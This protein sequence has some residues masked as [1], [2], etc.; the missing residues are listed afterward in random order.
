MLH[1]QAMQGS[2]LSCTLHAAVAAAARLSSSHVTYISLRCAA[3]AAIS[4]GNPRREA[5]A[6]SHSAVLLWLRRQASAAECG[7]PRVCPKANGTAGPPHWAKLYKYEQTWHT[8]R[9]HL[10]LLCLRR[11]FQLPKRLLE[12][13]QQA[14]MPPQVDADTPPELDGAD[15]SD[16]ASGM[17]AELDAADP[18][19]AAAGSRRNATPTDADDFSGPRDDSLEAAAARLAERIAERGAGGSA[20]GGSSDGG[21]GGRKVEG[22]QWEVFN[23]MAAGWGDEAGGGGRG[24][25]RREA[26]P[27]LEQLPEAA[28]AAAAEA[29]A[30]VPVLCARCHSLTHSGWAARPCRLVAPAEASLVDV[31]TALSDAP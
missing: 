16:E 10:G 24:G 13:L 27:T 9:C 23:D 17:H 6:E 22:D 28:A 12:Q 3:S 8:S 20:A 1:S 21:G 19:S 5:V 4:N 7:C 11:Y 25:G 30:G 26:G 29:A 31:R 15:G 14:A 18:A 2:A